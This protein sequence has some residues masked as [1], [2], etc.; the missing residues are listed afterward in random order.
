LA[1]FVSHD[2]FSRLQANEVG[3]PDRIE[4]P[5]F[6]TMKVRAAHRDAVIDAGQELLLQNNT[7]HLVERLSRLGIVVA[8]V[9]TLDQALEGDLARSRSM[10]GSV[11]MSAG[12]I[13]VVGNPIKISGHETQ[14]SCHPILRE[15]NESSSPETLSTPLPAEERLRRQRSEHNLENAYSN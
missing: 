9:K 5:R 1:L 8:G 7:A 15:H 14:Y 6:A 10:V 2:G 13:R 3:R 12:V 11:P 4:D